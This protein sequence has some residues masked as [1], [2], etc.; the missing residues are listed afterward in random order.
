MLA[1]RGVYVRSFWSFKSLADSCIST[2]S[3]CRR[4]DRLFRDIPWNSIEIEEGYY[5]CVAAE[6]LPAVFHYAS[7]DV[8]FTFGKLVSVQKWSFRSQAA[9]LGRLKMLTYRD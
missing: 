4:P 9:L 7:L 8:S 6:R 5:N 3:A 2:E 1:E